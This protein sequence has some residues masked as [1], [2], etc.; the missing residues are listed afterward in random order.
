MKFNSI[1]G[2]TLVNFV[3]NLDR[4]SHFQRLSPPC[5]CKGHKSRV[6]PFSSFSSDASSDFWQFLPQLLF[7]P[8][9]FIFL[10]PLS[11]CYL[12]WGSKSWNCQL[13]ISVYSKRNLSLHLYLRYFIHGGCT[14]II[15]KVLIVFTDNFGTCTP[16][17]S[18]GTP[19]SHNLLSLD[20]VQEPFDN[21]SDSFLAGWS[22]PWGALLAPSWKRFAHCCS[23]KC[24]ETPWF[25]PYSSIFFDGNLFVTLAI[26]QPRWIIFDG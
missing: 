7:F 13:G 10:E 23:K 14:Y 15:S 5:F 9:W 8:R 24:W 18:F 2:Q 19:H 26:L 4:L 25:L 22:G 6:K 11:L 1:F 12:L 20:R 16:A 3:Q 21:C 17:I